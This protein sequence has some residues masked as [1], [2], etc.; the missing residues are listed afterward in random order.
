VRDAVKSWPIRPH[1]I[2][3]KEDKFKAF[4]CANASLAASGTVT[5]ELALTG[6]AMVVAYKYDKLL[7]LLRPLIKADMFALANH[8]LGKKAFPEYIQYDC[9]PEN[10]TRALAPLFDTTSKEYK[11]QKSHLDQ[12]EEN[13]FAAGKRPSI[14]AARQAIATIYK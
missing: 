8:I 14:A 1:I 9:T 6:T 4:K 7:H 3:G 5:L 2:E 13:M 10:I 11:E 12:I